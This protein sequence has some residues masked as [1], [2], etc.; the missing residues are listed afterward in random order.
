MFLE[1]NVFL[2]VNYYSCHL[3]GLPDSFFQYGPPCPCGVR[4]QIKHEIILKTS[5]LK[6]KNVQTLRKTKITASLQNHNNRKK[7]MTDYY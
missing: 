2:A 5:R 3:E 1:V 6:L 7:K 4:G